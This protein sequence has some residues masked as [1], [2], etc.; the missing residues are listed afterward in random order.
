MVQQRSIVIVG[1]GTAGWLTAAYLARAL[2]SRATITLLE[3]P[4][5][6]IIGVGEGA[7]PTIRSTLR[8]IGIDEARFVRE[9]GATFKQGVRFDDWRREAVGDRRHRYL[10]PFDAP[11]QAD[12]ADLVAHWLAKDPATRE[13]FAEAMTI[14][15]RVADAVRAPKQPSEGDYDGPLAY[16]YHFDAH[17]LAALL[18]A[19]AVE[20]GVRHLQGELTGVETGEQGIA[21]VH[22]DAHGALTADL[23]VD[24]SGFRAELLGRA[25]RVGP[26]SAK[27]HLFTDRALAC[28]IAYAGPDAPI[29]SVT[30]ATAHEAGWIWDI[31]LQ[32]ARGLGC[33]Y[34]S[35]HLSDARAAEILC[36][37]VGHDRFEARIIPFEP[38][39]RETQWVGNCVAVG[40]AGGFLEPLE[41][42]GIVLI[43]AAAAMIADFLPM[44]GPVDASAGRFN[45]L[46]NARYAAIT[47]F[48]KLHY[49]LSQRQTAFWRDNAD[50]ASIPDALAA[51]LAEWRHR[52]PSRFD[53]QGGVE[54]FA[55][56]NYQ[57]VLYGMGFETDLG[58]STPPRGEQAHAERLFERIRSFGRQAVAEL[59]EHRALIREIGQR[60]P[61]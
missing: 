20:L 28:K 45:Q 21:C 25:L 10:H 49:C 39:W 2:G 60:M 22:T 36:G 12:D 4:G 32:N 33:V 29:E 1:G 6:G 11:Y 43:E 55:A 9:A 59:P 14:Q 44:A 3:S 16:A 51:L 41:S 46:M 17:R 34:S 38:G 23:Y 47:N 50:A 52:P 31:G 48:L 27:A 5:I 8:F 54:S 7:F 37:Y 53:F 19:R 13:P 15:N 42:T 40:L 26:R 35:A 61:A 30:T 24:C 56:F 18:R 58:P 57:Y